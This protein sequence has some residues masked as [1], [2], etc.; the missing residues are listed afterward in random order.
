MGY[1]NKEFEEFIISNFKDVKKL[2]LLQLTLSYLAPEKTHRLAL[3]DT[4][5]I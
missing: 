5:I 1:T 3:F 2:Y 4:I